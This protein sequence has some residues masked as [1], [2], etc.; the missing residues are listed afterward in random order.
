MTKMLIVKIKHLHRTNL[1]RHNEKKRYWPAMECYRRR[2]TT[3]DDARRQRASLVWPPILCVGGP[4][5][6]EQ[7]YQ[8]HLQSVISQKVDGQ[9]A[10]TV[11]GYFRHGCHQQFDVILHRQM[12]TFQTTDR[13]HSRLRLHTTCMTTTIHFNVQ[14]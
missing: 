1:C 8:T 12:F 13:C 4:I 5:I 9:K 3:V 14:P 11:T 7:I 10:E 2:Q 6:T